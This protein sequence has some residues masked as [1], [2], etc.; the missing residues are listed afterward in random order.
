MKKIII[1]AILAVAAIALGLTFTG[2]P[3]S[4]NQKA[5]LTS[6]NGML[7]AEGT[8][9]DFGTISMAAGKVTHAFKIKNSGAESVTVTKLYTSCMCTEATLITA[10]ARIG[11]IGMQGMGFIPT[12][13]E[14]VAPGK[15]ITVEATF[16]PAAHGPAGIGRIDRIVSLENNTGHNLELEIHA[17]VTP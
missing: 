1:S 14:N 11:P 7:T 13:K 5:N 15:E 6:S 4:Q 9:F 10:K 3:A 12:L 17:A 2:K 16:D 8:S